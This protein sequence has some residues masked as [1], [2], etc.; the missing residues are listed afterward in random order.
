MP[1]NQAARKQTPQAAGTLTVPHVRALFALTWDGEAKRNVDL[2]KQSG[3]GT[4]LKGSGFGRSEQIRN[5]K[6]FCPASTK[7]G[8]SKPRQY[9]EREGHGFSRAKKLPISRGFRP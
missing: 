1:K 4:V 5:E 2:V 9:N 3:D 8:Q 7:R 6:G